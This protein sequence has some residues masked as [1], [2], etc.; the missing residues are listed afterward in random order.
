MD[1]AMDIVIIDVTHWSADGGLV[2]LPLCFLCL[3]VE[4]SDMGL[5]SPLLAH[6]ILVFLLQFVSAKTKSLPEAALIPCSFLPV[7]DLTLLGYLI[8]SE[9]RK[10]HYEGFYIV[11]I[12]QLKCPFI[13]KNGAPNGYKV[14]ISKPI[15]TR[16]GGQGK[17]QRRRWLKLPILSSN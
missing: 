2:F 7:I 3:D 12:L 11:F 9:L 16:Y 14:S 6:L 17:S 4:E 10:L 1:R 15:T 13:R 8:H 5:S